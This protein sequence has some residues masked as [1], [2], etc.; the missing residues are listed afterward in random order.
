M[1]EDFNNFVV[2]HP[3]TIS[4]IYIFGSLLIGCIIQ[5][6]IIFISKIINKLTTI[7][8]KELIKK[9][10]NNTPI[11]Y[12]GV[13]GIYNV[14]LRTEITPE[15]L[16]Q[17]KMA[18]YIFNIVIVTMLLFRLIISYSSL[19]NKTN[20]G[21]SKTSIFEII[22]RIVL[23]IIAGTV[24]LRILGISITPILTALGVRRSCCCSCTSRYIIKSFFR[25][26]CNSF[27]SNKTRRFCKGW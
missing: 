19:K 18:F 11:I 2:Y 27:F 22:L 20:R 12:M 7:N 13:Y 14:I 24:I 23:Y 1:A 17:L 6:L 8:F 15:F 16:T 10:I 9:T 4:F 3:Y 21:F 26:I 25:S 5:I